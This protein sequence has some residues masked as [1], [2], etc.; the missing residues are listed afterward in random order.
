MQL[1]ELRKLAEGLVPSLGVAKEDD[2]GWFA[3]EL[4]KAGQTVDMEEAMGVFYFNF[5]DKSK[6]DKAKALA[7][8][9]KIEIQE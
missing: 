8:K 7:E 9:M 6:A 1:Y 5:K 2:A 3:V 4:A